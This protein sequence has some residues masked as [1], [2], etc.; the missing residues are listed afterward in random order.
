[1]G[2][3]VS[4]H[5]SGVVRVCIDRP[6]RRNA[7][8]EEMFRTLAALWSRL[9]E[10]PSV[11]CI[12]LRGSGNRAFCSGADLSVDWDACTD[13]DQ[14]I[15]DALLKT[16][17]F[18]KP[19]VAAINGHCVAGGLELALSAD[20]R[21]ASNEA[22]FGLPEVRFGIF[23]SGGGAQKLVDTIPQA[24]AME[25]LLT[26]KLISADTALRVGLIGSVHGLAELDRWAESSA[27]QIATN[28]PAAV[29]GVKELCAAI[30]TRRVKDCLELEQFIVDQVRASGQHKE[31]VSAFLEKR[32][33]SY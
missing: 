2:I 22:L 12:I 30:Q 26:G 24:F 16:K 31:G 11:R 7:L 23:P 32:P 28:S 19:I 21:A 15:D 14:L 25:M 29:Q 27:N 18:K 17:I 8:N 6:K 33:T 10:D 20:L 4:T 9:N 13:R 3:D 5:S 1:M